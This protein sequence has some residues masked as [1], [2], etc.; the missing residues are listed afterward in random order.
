MSASIFNVTHEEGR[1][2]RGRESDHSDSV[3]VYSADRPVG[4]GSD[5]RPVGGSV[6]GIDGT[7]R[8]LHAGDAGVGDAAG[9][10]LLHA[11]AVRATRVQAARQESGRVVRLRPDRS[12]GDAGEVP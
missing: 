8:T 1:S 7:V 3:A 4:S 10:R 2:Q 12:D 6:A 11:A 9:C 5:S